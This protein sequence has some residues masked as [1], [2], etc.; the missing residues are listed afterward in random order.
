MTV[1]ILILNVLIMRTIYTILHD[2]T[3]LY[4]IFIKYLKLKLKKGSRM[5]IQYFRIIFLYI[6]FLVLLFK[7]YLLTLN[8]NAS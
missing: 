4:Y 8:F 2:I 6:D 5:F 3:L 1:G 7:F